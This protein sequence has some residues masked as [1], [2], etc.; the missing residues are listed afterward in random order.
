MLAPTATW[1]DGQPVIVFGNFELPNSVLLFAAG[2]RCGGH[3]IWTIRV[4]QEAFLAG[5]FLSRPHVQ[6]YW[7]LTA[8]AKHANATAIL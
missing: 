7:N 3:G 2:Q 1:F 4:Q 8:V 6:A 5:E